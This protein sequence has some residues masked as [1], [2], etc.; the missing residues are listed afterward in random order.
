MPEQIELVTAEEGGEWSVEDR[1]FVMQSGFV[2]KLK[3]R[4]QKLG[5][6]AN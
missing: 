3:K 4:N 6:T 1:W 5:K 2:V